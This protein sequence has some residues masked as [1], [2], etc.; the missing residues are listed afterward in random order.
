MTTVITVEKLGKKYTLQLP[1]RRE[2]AKRVNNSNALGVNPLNQ[3]L[4]VSFASLR[5]KRV[6][7]VGVR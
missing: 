3:V 4:L 7:R 2:D 6:K 5:L 1:Q